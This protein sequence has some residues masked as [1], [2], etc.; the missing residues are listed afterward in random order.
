MATTSD[1]GLGEFTFPR[2]WFMVAAADDVGKKPLP[3]RYFGRDAVIYRGASGRAYMLDAYCPHM[4][5]HLGRNTTSYVVQDGQVEGDSIRCPYH[6]WRFG[7]DGRCDH[8]PYHDGPIP[9]AAAIRTW[10][11]RE[12]LGAVWTW[13]DP[14][15]GP[16]DY[17]LPALPE[18]DQAGWIRYE[19][20]RLGILHSH[21]QEIV[22]NIVDS[23]H[24]DPIHGG[25]LVWWETEFRAHQAIQREGNMHRSL[26]AQGQVLEIDAVYHGPGFLLTAML[27]YSNTYILIMHTP[28]D[29][30][31]VKVWH[32]L[33]VKSAH[34]TPT[35]AD[36]A[37]AR[38]YQAAS[39]KAFA[40]DFEVWANKRPATEIL[41]VASDGPFHKARLWYRQFYN[42]RA[43]RDEFLQPVEGKHYVRGLPHSLAEARAR[44]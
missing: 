33:L 37:A 36:V 22:D 42:P 40:Q 26:Q 6:G 24:V 13:H 21:P 29:D 9:K 5:T 1:Y 27:G 3:V 44:S 16:P 28:V 20:D 23:G 2:G 38:D 4:G 7:T 31:S 15:G 14:E 10:T 18:Y 32:A 41:Q 25:R 19:F 12:H 17:E 30:G 8:I 39:C 34:E 43:R 11:L 35:D